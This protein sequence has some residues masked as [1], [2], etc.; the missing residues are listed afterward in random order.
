MSMRMALVFGVVLTV[1]ACGSVDGSSGG[2]ET[3]PS[4][5][6]SAPGQPSTPRVTFPEDLVVT[7]PGGRGAVI[8]V[9][10]TVADGVEAGCLTITDAQGTW[11]LVGATADLKPGDTVTLRGTV[12]EDLATICQQGRAF[13]VDEVLER[14]GG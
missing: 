5:G 2:S 7:P 12:R 14:Q 8:T 9:T 6:S 10:G 1:A 3:T 11:T 4:A 13:W